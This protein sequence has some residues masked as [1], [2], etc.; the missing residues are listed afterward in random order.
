MATHNV[1]SPCSL[2]DLGS[3]LGSQG[4]SPLPLPPLWLQFDL[5]LAGRSGARDYDR[6]DPL[7]GHVGGHQGALPPDSMPPILDEVGAEFS[8]PVS[9]KGERIH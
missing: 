5:C 8:K 7:V 2:Y 6:L 4:V 9:L 3:L 1:C